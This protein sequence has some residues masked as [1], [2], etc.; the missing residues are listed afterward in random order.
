MYFV[1][2]SML[3]SRTGLVYIAEMRVGDFIVCDCFI[4]FQK[5]PAGMIVTISSAINTTLKTSVNPKK[6]LNR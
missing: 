1:I 3:H 2:F 6:K 4:N 5:V